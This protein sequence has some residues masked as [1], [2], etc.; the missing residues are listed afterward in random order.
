[1]INSETGNHRDVDYQVDAEF[2]EE[3]DGYKVSFSFV[4]PANNRGYYASMCAT[5]M[6]ER[7]EGIAIFD[8]ESYAFDIGHRLAKKNIDKAHS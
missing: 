6:N 1:M 4:G 2:V 5:V 3:Q 7:T 8:E